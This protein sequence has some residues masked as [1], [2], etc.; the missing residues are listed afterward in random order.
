MQTGKG[1][2]KLQ[3]INNNGAT[4]LELVVVPRRVAPRGS[5]QGENYSGIP[6]ACATPVAV[7]TEIV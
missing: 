1:D 3:G 4:D 6:T 7:A 2:T 5:R